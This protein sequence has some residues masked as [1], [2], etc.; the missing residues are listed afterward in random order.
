MLSV[1]CIHFSTMASQA[2][3]TEEGPTAA[4]AQRSQATPHAAAA[5]S[6]VLRWSLVLILT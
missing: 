2:G 3:G 1:C 4:L 5:A 6:L